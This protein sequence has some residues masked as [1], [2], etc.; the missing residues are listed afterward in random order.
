MHTGQVDLGCGAVSVASLCPGTL[1]P[2]GQPSKI[3]LEVTQHLPPIVRNQG[4]VLKG[5]VEGGWDG[6]W[7]RYRAPSL[8]V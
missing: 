6:A 2:A 4:Q 3:P 7:A 8:A 5:K 1:R